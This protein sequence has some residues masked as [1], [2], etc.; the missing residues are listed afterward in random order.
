MICFQRL[1]CVTAPDNVVLCRAM[2]QHAP[3]MQM[4]YLTSLSSLVSVDLVHVS[5]TPRLLRRWAP[6]LPCPASR[7]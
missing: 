3:C 6:L 5:A 7:H 1:S 2:M 4:D